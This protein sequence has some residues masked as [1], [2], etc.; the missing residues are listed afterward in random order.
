M[1]LQG[2]ERQ[3]IGGV[4]H[5]GGGVDDLED[6]LGAGQGGL[7]GVVHVGKLLERADEALAVGDEGGD[8]AD[9]DQP[10]QRQLAAQAGQNDDEEIAQDVGER[11]EQHGVDVG[12]DGRLVDGLVALAEGFQ[13]RVVAAEGF[14]DLLP[15]DGFFHD[16][17][18]AAKL[19]LQ[20]A[21]ALAGVAG[22][23]IGEPAT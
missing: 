12:V 21:E 20:L 14:D 13:S 23:E 2:G 9:A 7:D 16:A 1:A 6:P 11:H 17:V 3:G 15:A 10:A 5:F 22:D 4:L 19:L 8:H 18:H